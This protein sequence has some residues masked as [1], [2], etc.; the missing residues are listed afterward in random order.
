MPYQTTSQRQ[1]RR[2]AAAALCAL[3]LT[4]LLLLSACGNNAPPVEATVAPAAQATS[5]TAPEATAA[6]T[7]AAAPT[8]VPEPTA[9]PTD[10]PPPTSAPTPTAAATAEEVTLGDCDN[11]FFPV[12]SGHV[13]RYRNNIPGMGESEFAQTFGDVT[14]NSFTIT[15]GLGEGQSL[16]QNWQC[17]AEGLLAP[18]MS[19]LPGVGQGMSVEYLEASGIT[20]PRDDQ[21][22]PGQEW[23]T[24]YV[25][26]V[27]MADSGAG[28]MILSETVDMTNTVAGVESVSVPAGDYDAVRVDTQG[29]ISFSIGGSA[30]TTTELTMTSWYAEDV[31]LVRQELAGLLSDEAIATELV[32]VE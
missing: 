26:E 32:S 25:V 27:T 10:A 24:H 5:A 2:R 9:A 8:D 22:E 3:L 11:R 15:L 31:G 14:D 12:V 30:P 23:N 4:A 16:V 29:T 6:P 18:E 20:L 7:Q 28:Q 19:G 13:L 1:A 17:G 21:M